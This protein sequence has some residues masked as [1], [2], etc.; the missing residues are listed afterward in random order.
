MSSDGTQQ[1]IGAERALETILGGEDAPTEEEKTTPAQ[2]LEILEAKD[3]SID[4]YDAHAQVMA[5]YIIEA[6]RAHEG[7]HHA[8]NST[9]YLHP[10]DWDNPVVLMPD[11]T[12]VMKKVYPDE[13]HPFRKAL[14]GATGFSWGWAF[15]IARY[16]LGLPPQQNP[17]LMEIKVKD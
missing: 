3:D 11:L 7:L 13:S 8:P 2:W 16:A 15:N 1:G 14:S 12:D 5:K 9:V 6:Y 17:A 4:G 10:I